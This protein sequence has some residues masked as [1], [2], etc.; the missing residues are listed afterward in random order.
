MLADVKR[1]ALLLVFAILAGCWGGDRPDATL[2]P[3]EVPPGGWW[4]APAWRAFLQTWSDEALATL[5]QLPPASLTPDERQALAR[6]TLAETGASPAAIAALETR[7]AQP[8]P[9]SYKAFLEASAGWHQL[10]MDATDGH[11]WPPAKVGWFRDQQP[12]WLLTWTGANFPD[13]DDGTYFVYGPQQDPVSLRRGYLK[14]TLAISEGIESAIYLLNPRVVSPRGEWEAWYFGNAL[15]G[16]YR[17][18]SF[19]ALMMVERGRTLAA[20]R[21]QR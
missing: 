8:L 11:L 3:D 19:Q 9:P 6:G 16:A 20:L 2:I 7:L 17:Y 15:P 1:L 14:S 18:H 4:D 12:A 21:H 10:A 5:R 13:P